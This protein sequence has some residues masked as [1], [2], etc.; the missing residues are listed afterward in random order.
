M[1]AENWKATWSDTVSRI[2][3]DRALSTPVIAEYAAF[4]LIG[5]PLLDVRFSDGS[6]RNLIVAEL[7]AVIAVVVFLLAMRTSL[8]PVRERPSRPVVTCLVFLLAGVLRFLVLHFVGGPLEYEILWNRLP[9]IMIVSLGSLCLLAVFESRRFQHAATLKKLVRGNEAELVTAARY[10]ADVANSR[11]AIEREVDRELTP[12]LMLIQE[13]LVR[14][15]AADVAE[16]DS[17]TAEI[18]VETLAEL[19]RPLSHRLHE[20]AGDEEV[21]ELPTMEYQ[22]WSKLRVNPAEMIK[23]GPIAC[24]SLLLVVRPT[25]ILGFNSDTISLALSIALVWGLLRV[26]RKVWP[27]RFRSMALW[28]AL[29][30][31]FLG[32]VGVFCASRIIVIIG[33]SLWGDSGDA[34]GFVGLLMFVGFGVS[35]ASAVTL[36]VAI[37]RRQSQ[38]E[39]S[40]SQLSDSI[41]LL[42]ARKRKQLWVNRRNLS[43]VLHGP[44]QSA[45]LS[46]AISLSQSDLTEAQRLAI[47][48]RIDQAVEHLAATPERSSNMQLALSELTTVWA[49]TCAI[50]VELSDEIATLLAEDSNTSRCVSEIAREGISNAVRHG[51]ATSIAV[52][53]GPAS[54]DRLRI[55]VSD[56]GNGLASEIT[57]GLGSAI[58]DELAIEWSRISLGAGT[59]LTADVALG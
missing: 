50:R 7:V 1:S 58:L 38:V 53:F 35:L 13:R 28:P 48:T 10:E 14:P 15:D 33:Q 23:P 8:L 27:P 9:G 46:G 56:N 11:L 34:V 43:W 21:I 2:G 57:H 22:S 30:T 37:A 40:L 59:I 26:A 39:E 31:L 32:Y 6:L 17:E 12:T 51:H 25:A 49:D 18:I 45:M 52:V 4:A 55:T 3:S 42:T 44:L 16:Y 24:V 29:I 36:L 20:L 47:S 5:G 41:A 54:S 19:I